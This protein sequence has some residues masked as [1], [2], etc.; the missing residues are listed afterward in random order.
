MLRLAVLGDPVAHSL[1]PRFQQAAL[2]AAGLD[3][4]Y[5]AIRCPADALEARLAALAAAGYRGLNLT[6][7]LKER[8]WA[9]L[10][11]RAAAIGDAAARLAAVNTL[12]LETD[13]R[14]RLDNTDL[15]GCRAAAESLLGAPLTGRR[16]LVLGAGGAGRAAVAACLDGGCD[17]VLLWN[18]SPERARALQRALAPDDARLAV[19]ALVDGRCPGGVDLVIQATRLGLAADDPLPP[20]PAAGELPAALDLVTQS[21]A[22]QRACAAAGSRAADGREMLLAQGAASFR[23]WT[24]RDA[25][26]AAMRTALFGAP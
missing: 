5:E 10:A 22:W 18:R 12:R 6:L 19:H 16:V 2:D 25:P 1:S 11:P 13:G 9:L 14:W 4:R 26:L 24:G 8:A 3:G 15:E 7:P 17:A 23:L 21:T 20:L